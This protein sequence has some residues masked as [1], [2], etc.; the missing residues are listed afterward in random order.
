MLCDHFSFRTFALRKR[1]FTLG[2]GVA[3]RRSRLTQPFEKDMLTGLHN[4]GTPQAKAPD[5]CPGAL[6]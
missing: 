3:L 6:F 5:G 4:C 2:A 1:C